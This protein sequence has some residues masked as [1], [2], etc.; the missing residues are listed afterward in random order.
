MA[1]LISNPKFETNTTGWNQIAGATRVSGTTPPGT[2]PIGSTT[3]LR[4]P[5]AQ[6]ST[7][8]TQFTINIPPADIYVRYYIQREDDD[9]TSLTVRIKDISNTIWY[10]F[11]HNVNNTS[12]TWL[13]VTGSFNATASGTYTLEIEPTGI[14]GASVLYV[15]DFYVG[16]SS[17]YCFNKGTEILCLKNN[18]EQYIPI[19]TINKETDLIKTYRHGYKKVEGVYHSLFKNNI[20]DYKNSMYIM[21]KQENMTKDLIVT[22]GHS[23]LVDNYKTDELRRKHKKTFGSKLDPIDDK[24]L[25]LA[26]FSDSFVQ[27]KGDDIYDIYHIVLEDEDGKSKRYGIWANGVLTESAYKNIL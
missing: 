15:T 18:I 5:I 12:T 19:E 8:S 14:T 25:L 17:N 3:S 24:Q 1:N 2:T 6:F 10:T 23:I 26:G 20:N 13:Q 4:I 21:K 22:G 9:P 16:T 7:I 27:I 11:S